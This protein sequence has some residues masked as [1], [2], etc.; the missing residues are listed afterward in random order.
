VANS[1]NTHLNNL[2]T[3]LKLN[4]QNAYRNSPYL[5]EITVA[6]FNICDRLINRS[7]NSCFVGQVFATRYNYSKKLESKLNKENWSLLKEILSKL[8]D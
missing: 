2:Y 6:I 8:T 3:R 7:Y 4:N 5:I 1:I